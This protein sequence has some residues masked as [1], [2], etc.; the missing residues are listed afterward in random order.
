MNR[1]SNFH[2]QDPFCVSYNL[3][4]QLRKFGNMLELGIDTL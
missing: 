4:V 2:Y 3:R 1:M